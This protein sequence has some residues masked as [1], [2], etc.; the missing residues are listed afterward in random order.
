MAFLA[1]DFL[2]PGRCALWMGQGKV[3]AFCKVANAWGCMVIMGADGWLCY[4]S[5]LGFGCC[6]GHRFFAACGLHGQR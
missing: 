2:D 6:L 5:C 1:D 3:N 4:V